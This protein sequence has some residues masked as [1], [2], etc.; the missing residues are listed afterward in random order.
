MPF[1]TQLKNIDKNADLMMPPDV[2]VFS[3]EII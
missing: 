1:F 2:K 3:P